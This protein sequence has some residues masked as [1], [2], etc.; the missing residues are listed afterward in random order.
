MAAD[1]ASDTLPQGDVIAGQEA[2]TSLPNIPI[3]TL[4]KIQVVY[5]AWWPTKVVYKT[6]EELEAEDRRNGRYDDR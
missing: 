3:P 2:V 4:P 6:V 1:R 5:K